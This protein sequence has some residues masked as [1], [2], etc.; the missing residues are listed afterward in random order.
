MNDSFIQLIIDSAESHRDKT[1]M[2]IVGEDAEGKYT[3]GCAAT[4]SKIFL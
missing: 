4:P 1:A 2:Q 3:F